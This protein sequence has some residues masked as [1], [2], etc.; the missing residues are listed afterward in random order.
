MRELQIR[1]HRVEKEIDEIVEQVVE[2]GDRDLGSLPTKRPSACRKEDEDLW[3]L[4][5]NEDTQRIL[6]I[7][8]ERWLEEVYRL[9]RGEVFNKIF[10]SGYLA[11]ARHV[12]ERARGACSGG[13]VRDVL[14]VLELELIEKSKRCRQ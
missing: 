5:K 6:K 4:V 11:A 12:G 7:Y 13:I 8:R 9:I 14:E 10:A 3:N 2:Q 1:T